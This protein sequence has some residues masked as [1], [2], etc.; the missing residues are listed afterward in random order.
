M[1]GRADLEATLAG[2]EATLHVG[3]AVAGDAAN[4]DRV[5]RLLAKARKALRGGPFGAARGNASKNG[6][7]MRS[8]FLGAATAAALLAAP[9][10]ADA[11]PTSDDPATAR[12]LRIVPAVDAKL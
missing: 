8:S 2:L 6:E 11:G 4:A 1:G 7:R 3:M 10:P 9:S 12:P 5:G